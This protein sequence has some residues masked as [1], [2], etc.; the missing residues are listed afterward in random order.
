VRTTPLKPLADTLLV[1]GSIVQSL[2][3][4]QQPV[5]SSFDKLCLGFGVI[6]GILKIVHILTEL[7]TSG[8]W[9]V[10][11]ANNIANL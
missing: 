5:E 6:C 3:E 11:E 1:S 2:Y 7:A 10:Q 4:T 9:P 8:C